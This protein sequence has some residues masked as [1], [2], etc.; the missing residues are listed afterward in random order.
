MVEGACEDIT[1]D[2]V[3]ILQE[4]KLMARYGKVLFSYEEVDN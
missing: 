4:A 3:D 2:T 1:R